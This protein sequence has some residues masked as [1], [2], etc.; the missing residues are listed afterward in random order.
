ME[1][2]TV[3][4]SPS[5]IYHQGELEPITAD[6]ERGGNPRRKNT[7][8]PPT[9]EPSNREVTVLLLLMHHCAAVSLVSYRF[10]DPEDDYCQV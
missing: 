1:D 4:F 3:V 7:E 8:R 2:S 5:I 6:R 9:G 10:I